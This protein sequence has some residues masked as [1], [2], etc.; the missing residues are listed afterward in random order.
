MNEQK[1][2]GFGGRVPRGKKWTT[3]HCRPCCKTSTAPCRRRYLRTPSRRRI[4]PTIHRGRRTPR[5]PRGPQTLPTHRRARNTT[6]WDRITPATPVRPSTAVWVVSASAG[7][8][9]CAYARTRRQIET[10]VGADAT[11]NTAPIDAAAA[12]NVTKAFVFFTGVL[13]NELRPGAAQT[14]PACR[15]HAVH[16]CL[17]PRPRVRPA[18][19]SCG[20]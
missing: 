19:L 10:F 18:A 12:A 3:A 4:H 14:M 6:N 1:S 11:R 13:C 20:S 17:A 5:T 8:V 7:A 9:G 2:A 15:G 16:V